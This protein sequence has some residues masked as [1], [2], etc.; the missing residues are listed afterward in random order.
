MQL[1]D[2]SSGMENQGKI[3]LINQLDEFIHQISRVDNLPD[4]ARVMESTL[5]DLTDV[6][7][8]GLFLFDFLENKLKLLFAKGFT[9]E[10]KKAS[11]ATAMERHI[12][13]VFRT[14]RM[15]HIPD[16]QQ[17]PEHLTSDS[18]RGFTVRSRLSLPVM[19]GERCVGVFGNASTKINGFTDAHIAILRFICDAAGAIYGYLVYREEL[20]KMTHIIRHTDNV[21][22]VTDREGKVD[23][24]NEAFTRVNNYPLKE[25]KGVRLIDLLS[26]PGRDEASVNR[27]KV[28][29]DRKK[30][31]EIDLLNY[32]K[33]GQ[34]YWASH[35]LQ[36]IFNFN[37]QFTH[38]I[39]L[40]RDIT[41]KKRHLLE[42]ETTS[43]RLT[44]LLQTLHTGILVENDKR[45][46]VLVNQLFCEYFRVPMPPQA[47][48]GLDC[49]KMLRE[50]SSQF[51]DP[52]ATLS[53][54]ETIL[55]EKRAVLDEQLILADGR[56]FERD[57]LPIYSK[58]KFFGNLWR[59]GDI[60]SRKQAERELFQAK[61]EAEAAN[62]AK[63]NF[64]ANMSH[65]I[66][67]PLNVIS[68]LLSL[69]QD[70]GLT[71]DQQYLMNGLSGAA[72]GL[73]DIVNDIL[74]F[75]KIEA[76]QMTL[77]ETPFNLCDLVVKTFQFLEFKATEKN[78]D[79]N[80]TIEK[81]INCHLYG[82]HTRLRQII[83]NLVNNAI[84]FTQGGKIN[85]D[86]KYVSDDEHSVTIRFSVSD[87][88]IGIAS[89]NI[90][91]VFQSF[92]QEDTSTTRNFG[93][94]GLGLA[95]SKQLVSL[96]GGT[97]DVESSKNIGSEFYFTLR[98]KKEI[99]KAVR[100]AIKKTV[101]LPEKLEGLRVLLVEDNEFNQF[102]AKSI[103]EK[104]KMIVTLANNGQEAVELLSVSPYDIVL[105][106]LHMPVMGGLEATEIIRGKLRLDVP[107]IALTANVVKEIIERCDTA[108]MND[109][110]S[111]PFTPDLLLEK[112]ANFFH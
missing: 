101:P 12:G 33:S 92:Q 52:Q 67:T 11:E 112:I 63:S 100:K 4:L 88:G 106:D 34:S 42:I 109:Y 3:T 10:E 77:E 87:T 20:S 71:S 73:L 51:A 56:V 91:K 59:Y 5:E 84:K 86:C 105:M 95:I 14:K 39:S 1:P 19:F 55:L 46:I 13:H 29:I 27:L 104:W 98:L 74:D 21:V 94:T 53:R 110:L 62:V 15:L 49:E 43:S 40:Q 93:G 69:L 85:L 64:L 31:I 36:P 35:Q 103:L 58:D 37:K 102:I 18:P 17:D 54:V 24:V 79:L 72:E 26:G 44:T 7:Y 68:G 30:S 2:Q 22:V 60:T 50:A 25:V 76:G 97:L 48:I 61:Q 45:E 41:E 8:T 89:E 32:T 38:F 75:S 90:Y 28:A 107:I 23:W 6:E 83:I 47:M 99:S 81:K 16:V 66:R 80:F 70:T 57:Y 96:M 65:E 78:N 108:G 82:D 111:K 9:E